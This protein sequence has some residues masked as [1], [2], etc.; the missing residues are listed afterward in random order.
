MQ[1]YPPPC[2]SN[3]VMITEIIIINEKALNF[4]KM[5]FKKYCEFGDVCRYM[6][7]FTGNQ[8]LYMCGMCEK[9]GGK[10]ID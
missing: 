7:A 1:A 9:A 6:H 10:C 2:G 5:S 3:Q 8:T 4:V